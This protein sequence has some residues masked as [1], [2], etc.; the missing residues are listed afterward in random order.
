MAKR[1]FYQTPTQTATH[2]VN[3]TGIMINHSPASN[4]CCTGSSCLLPYFQ[5][6]GSV[7]RCMGFSYLKPTH[8]KGTILSISSFLFT[9][10]RYQTLPLEVAQISHISGRF[11]QTTMRLNS[12]ITITCFSDCGHKFRPGKGEPLSR[13][14]YCISSANKITTLLCSFFWTTVTNGRLCAECMGK[15][16]YIQFTKFT[17]ILSPNNCLRPLDYTTQ[18]DKSEGG[19]H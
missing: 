4:S 2:K 14:Y 8:G 15:I 17:D 7:A 18:P 11:T 6:K 16:C 9:V 1:G 3:R 12:L 19:G 10:C 13:K 5:G